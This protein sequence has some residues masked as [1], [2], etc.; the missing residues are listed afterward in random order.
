MA[1]HCTKDRDNMALWNWCVTEV[2]HPPFMEGMVR[3]D[4][5]A[6]FRRRCISKGITDLSAMDNFVLGS[7]NSIEETR[8][9]V[10]N[11]VGINVIQDADLTRMGGA[12][13]STS[14]LLAA[15][16]SLD[17]IQL[18]EVEHGG[19]RFNSRWF[20]KHELLHILVQL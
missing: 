18:D 8:T 14:C 7:A 19:L 9:G 17:V 3:A 10:V 13:A 1:L 12:I 2:I 11:T 5:D 20:A 16:L 4:A 15:I 6:L